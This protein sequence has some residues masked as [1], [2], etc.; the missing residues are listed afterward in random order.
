[1]TIQELQ[2]KRS[3]PPERALNSEEVGDYLQV[4]RDWDL[5][6]HQIIKAFQFKNFYETMAFVNAVAYIVHQEDHHPDMEIGYSRCVVKFSTHSV[7]AGKGGLSENDFICAAKIES[8]MEGRR[9]P[10]SH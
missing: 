1:M 5:S 6:G 7:N 3:R 9:E 10:S 8:L 4:L 2:N